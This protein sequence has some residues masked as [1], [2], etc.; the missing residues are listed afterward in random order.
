MGKWACSSDVLA[1]ARLAF[2]LRAR[3]DAL[4]DGA[5]GATPA[6]LALCGRLL[7]LCA[8]WGVT[9]AVMCYLQDG[10]WGNDDGGRGYIDDDQNMYTEPWKP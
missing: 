8:S 10:P 1:P 2:G 3:S 6:I 9:H 5:S 7:R 4:A